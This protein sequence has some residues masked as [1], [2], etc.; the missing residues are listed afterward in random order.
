M[1]TFDHEQLGAYQN[2]KV[3]SESIFVYVNRLD[4]QKRNTRDQLS[5]AVESILY[6]I[7]EGNG[8]STATERRRFFRTAKASALEC[9]AIIDVLHIQGIVSESGREQLRKE[10]ADVIRPLSGLIKHTAGPR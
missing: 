3:F 4:S 5:R 1:V 8:K 6:N 9:A 7:A 10:L 2:A